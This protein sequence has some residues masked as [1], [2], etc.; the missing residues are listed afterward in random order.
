MVGSFLDKAMDWTVLP[1]F[2]R[3]GYEARRRGW[4]ELEPGALGGRSVLVTGA[5][6][7]IG[8]AACARIAELGGTAHMLVRDRRRGEAAR[9]RALGQIGGG[10]DAAERLRLELC[11]VS[12]LEAVRS[13]AADF[14]DRVGEL[15]GLVHN[16]GV[17]LGRRERSAQGYELTLATHVLGPL[18]LTE[19]LLRKLRDAAPSLV[20]F[21][22]SGGAYTAAANPEDPELDGEEFDGP[23]FYAHAKRVQI[24][25]AEEL[26]A[27]EQGSGVAFASE[28]P[29][30][31]D[32]PGLE[33]SLPRFHRLMR[34]LLRDADQGADTVV[35]LL[36]NPE[37]AARHPGALWHDRR[38]RPAHRLPR[39]RDGVDQRRRLMTELESLIRQPTD[40]EGK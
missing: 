39:T 36:A 35:W 31:A 15:H 21:V 23:R 20:C 27:R 11:D 33:R 8:A 25:L 18:L 9:R 4:K 28:H 16:A 3:L 40:N 12:D 7:G 37:A 30:W 34:P 5:S 1:G 22:T 13:F 19:L 38:P 14:S 6:S 10:G 26:A 32:T 17:L 24:I 29:G 2:T